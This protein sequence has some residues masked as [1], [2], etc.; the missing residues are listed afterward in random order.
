MPAHMSIRSQSAWISIYQVY[1]SSDP[2]VVYSV[3]VI[4]REIYVKLVYHYCL[5]ISDAVVVLDVDSH[6]CVFWT[7][8]Q[9][10]VKHTRYN[11]LYNSDLDFR[12]SL[13]SQLSRHAAVGV[14]VLC[15]HAICS[16][17]RGGFSQKWLKS[18]TG[19]VAIPMVSNIIKISMY[20]AII[21]TTNAHAPAPY[22]FIQTLSVRELCIQIATLN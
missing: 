3:V 14:I 5:L 6:H 9:G 16:F 20:Q 1:V 12:Y 4:K 19:S 2:N 15:I 13:S 18:P 11:V 10:S 7:L 21:Q 17:L 22:M 8:P